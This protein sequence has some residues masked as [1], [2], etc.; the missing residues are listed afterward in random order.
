MSAAVVMVGPGM[1]ILKTMDIEQHDFTQM[2]EFWKTALKKWLKE[3]PDKSKPM[4]EEIV[5]LVKEYKYL[6]GL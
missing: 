1:G 6:K 3:N 2:G 5:S 4:A